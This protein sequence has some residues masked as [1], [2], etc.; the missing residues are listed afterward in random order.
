MRQVVSLKYFSHQQKCIEH[1]TRERKS[2]WCNL[3]SPLCHV[4]VRGKRLGN[5]TRGKSGRVKNKKREAQALI[6]ISFEPFTLN[7]ALSRVIELTGKKLISASE[8]DDEEREQL[9]VSED[10]LYSRRP[11]Y[12]P[13]VDEC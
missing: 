9:G 13:A 10:V 4:H 12:V 7:G 11:L 1:F 5:W 8:N 2:I 3:G 6:F